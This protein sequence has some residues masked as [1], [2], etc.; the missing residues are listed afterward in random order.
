MT[1][2]TGSCM[3]GKASYHADTEALF[4]AH[5]HCQNCRKS[6]TTGHGSLILLP[7]DA[8]TV[9]GDLSRYSWTADSGHKI[10]KHFCGTCG[11]L[12]YQENDALPEGRGIAVNLLDDP[13]VFAAQMVVYS[14]RALSWDQPA[15][16]I[17]AFPEMPPIPGA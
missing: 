6:S 2:F 15:T 9:T 14:S 5:C 13:E 7:A 16:G 12:V 1:N 4:T 10:T 11:C 17:P 8:L 3:C